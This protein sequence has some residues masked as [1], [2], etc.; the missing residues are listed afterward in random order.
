MLFFNQI[1][2]LFEWGLFFFR[3]R[4]KILIRTV[5]IKDYLAS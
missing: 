5:K 3:F 1:E 2:D 4:G